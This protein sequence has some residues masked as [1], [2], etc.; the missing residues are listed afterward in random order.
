MSTETSPGS[1]REMSPTEMSSGNDNALNF[2]V[3]G[4]QTTPSAI[5]PDQGATSTKMAE[6]PLGNEKKPTRVQRLAR[7]WTGGP[8]RIMAF[9]IARGLAILGMMCAHE[10]MIAKPSVSGVVTGFTHGRSSALFAFLAGI[11]LAI[12]AG[13]GAIPT[14]RQL[15]QARMRIC[16]RAIL[17]LVI[18]GALS[19]VNVG[20]AIILDFYAMWFF[21]SLPVLR[22]HPRRLLI[23]AAVLSTA[24]P[25]VTAFLRIWINHTELVGGGGT[26]TFSQTVLF[27]IYAGAC[28]MTYILAGMALMRLGISRPRT[29]RRPLAVRMIVAGL[30]LF[31]LGTGGATAIESIQAGELSWSALNLE[32]DDG[33]KAKDSDKPDSWQSGPRDPNC[34]L[35]TD[36]PVPSEAEIT[37]RNK[38]YARITGDNSPQ[39]L[40]CFPADAGHQLQGQPIPPG[41]YYATDLM[42]PQ[43][44]EAENG[45]GPGK[46]PSFWTDLKD[47]LYQG[48]LAPEPHAN[49][50][51]ETWGNLGVCLFIVGI[52]LLLPR[53]G[54]LSLSP[55]AAMGSMALTA[56]CLHVTI[57]G[58]IMSALFSSAKDDPHNF[59]SWLAQAAILL[60]AASLWRLTGK[61]GP[62]EWILH[63][64]SH[65]AAAEQK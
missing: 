48:L 5:P 6:E 58:A 49:S 17:L 46:K 23:G 60:V 29:Q 18:T 27:G 2:Q 65:R 3:T 61:R 4:D 20:I 28:Y 50:V 12:I 34:D 53:W 19:F 62:L 16:V 8:G 43:E 30:L 39:P 44:R 33:G 13:R 52:L 21:L 45:D 38:E 32:V 59:V 64:T 37:A 9:D 11:S 42:T 54:L 55:I 1:G 22:W 41:C 36:V 35:P 63:A 31:T 24:G 47:E 25:L 7:A 15:L 51:L 10:I 26:D 40:R 14:G 57:H 56:Y